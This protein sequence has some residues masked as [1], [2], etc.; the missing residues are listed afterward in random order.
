M[1]GLGRKAGYGAVWLQGGCSRPAWRDESPACLR[2]R[3]CPFPRL[4]M[5]R[6]DNDRRLKC[7]YPIFV[8]PPRRRIILLCP[9]GGEYPASSPLTASQP[10]LSE[11]TNRPLTLTFIVRV[12]GLPLLFPPPAFKCIRTC[13]QTLHSFTHGLVVSF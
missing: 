4:H 3:M 6:K 13:D 10:P 2:L 12:L 11:V 8:V 7:W 9:T 5:N 1:Q